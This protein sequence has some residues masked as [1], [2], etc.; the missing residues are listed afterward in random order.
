[1]V[2]TMLIELPSREWTCTYSE[3][4]APLR[5]KQGRGYDACQ[6]A[7]CSHLPAGT[8]AVRARGLGTPVEDRTTAAVLAS[9][10]VS[11]HVVTSHRCCRWQDSVCVRP[12]LLCA[13]VPVV[14]RVCAG[15]VPWAVSGQGVSLWVSWGL[16]VAPIKRSV[17]SR[18]REVLLPLYSALV[19]PHLE[20]CVQFWAP[21][22]KQDE[23]VLER[24]QQKAT[25]MIRG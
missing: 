7:V 19:R 25:R 11:R 10:S 15:G 4:L 5:A 24:V 3:R 22:F 21:Q 13:P 8:T 17:A 9:W 23:E 1:M 12:V 20:Y 2:T 6:C 18:S 16:G 14:M